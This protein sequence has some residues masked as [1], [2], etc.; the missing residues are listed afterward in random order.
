MTVPVCYSQEALVGAAEK[1]MTSLAR[2]HLMR[3]LRVSVVCHFI[4]KGILMNAV[5]IRAF[6]KPPVSPGDVMMPQAMFVTT[7]GMK[8]K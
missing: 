3:T 6:G 2:A 7:R 8:N 5:P 4:R 1:W